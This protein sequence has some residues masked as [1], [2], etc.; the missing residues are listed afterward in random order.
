MKKIIFW[1][2][3][4]TAI[5]QVIK[6]LIARFLMD[7]EFAIIPFVFT[8]RTY[9]NIHLGWI[10]NRLDFMM[11]LYGAVIISIAGIVAAILIYRYFAKLAAKWGKYQRLPTAILIFTLSCALC[12]LIDDIFWGGSLDYIQLFNWFIFDLK[13][14]YATTAAVLAVYFCIVHDYARHRRGI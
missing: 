13:D 8:F 5:D 3:L 6:L 2:T 7:A 4:L 9:Q 11:P 14:V 12:K 1:I 10:W